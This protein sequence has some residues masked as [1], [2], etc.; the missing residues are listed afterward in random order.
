[1]YP[2]LLSFS[3]LHYITGNFVSHFPKKSPREHKIPYRSEV[4]DFEDPDGQR[5]VDDHG[6]EEQEDEEV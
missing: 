6:D 5:Q 2:T 4:H 1:M 3:V